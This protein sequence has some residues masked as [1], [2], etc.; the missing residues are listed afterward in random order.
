MGRCEPNGAPLMSRALCLA[1]MGRL[2][3]GAGFAAI[4]LASASAAAQDQT[5]HHS[6]SSFA[7]ETVARF[8]ALVPQATFSSDPLDPLQVSVT[9]HPEWGEA[10]LNLHRLYGYCQTVELE[11][12]RS[13]IERLMIALTAK[14]EDPDASDLRII[15]RDAQY[16]AYTEQI[17]KETGSLPVHRKIG[18][19]LY[20]ILA[21][22]GAQ[23]IRVAVPADLEA[24][25]LSQTVAWE[26]AAE[27]TGL[28]IPPLPL[29]RDFAGGLLG[30]EGDEYTGTMLLYLPQW[31]EIAARAGPDLVVSIT[32]DQLVIAGVMPE[33]ER[34]E[35]FK[36][37]VAQDCAAAAR[38]IS[39]H[40]YRFRDGQWAIAN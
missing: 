8:E 31:A 4:A 38:C 22:D 25:G 35:E 40:V 33:G 20:A 10:T 28:V 12:C 5:G 27:Q 18:D 26:R 1:L 37:L 30:F 32:S 24:F 6:P 16:W 36:T 11:V 21:L 17:A 13:E 29:G 2:K 7:E 19:D 15:I 34:L 3:R 23:T 14:V 39:P 9:D